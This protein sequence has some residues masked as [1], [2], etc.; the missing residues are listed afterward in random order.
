MLKLSAVIFVFLAPT[1]MGIFVTA[2]LVMDLH[3]TDGQ[4][5]TWAALAGLVAAIPAAWVVALQLS[6]LTGKA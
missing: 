5:L 1:L 2:F 6:K 3:T 4:G